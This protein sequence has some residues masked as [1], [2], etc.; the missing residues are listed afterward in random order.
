MVIEMGAAV[1]DKLEKWIAYED[2][3]RLG[4]M[5]SVDQYFAP[6]Y[7]THTWTLL[8]TPTIEPSHC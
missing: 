3:K 5:T 7:S 8:G 4:E 1:P 2:Q 6:E